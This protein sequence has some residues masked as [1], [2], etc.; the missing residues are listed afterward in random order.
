MQTTWSCHQS[1]QMFA[2]GHKPAHLSHWRCHAPTGA[3]CKCHAACTPGLTVVSDSSSLAPVVALW[4]CVSFSEL[5]AEFI[6]RIDGLVFFPRRS[7]SAPRRSSVAEPY[8]RRYGLLWRSGC[9][10]ICCM[11]L[12]DILKTSLLALQIVA[13][14]VSKLCAL[15]AG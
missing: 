15:V 5:L 9:Q 3:T 4:S 11:H 6:Q 12:S 8:S 13:A 7:V 10:T 14:T 2:G 1:Q